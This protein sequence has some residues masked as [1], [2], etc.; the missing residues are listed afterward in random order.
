[1]CR[2]NRKVLFDA[3]TVPPERHCR[4]FLLRLL[5]RWRGTIL[6]DSFQFARAPPAMTNMWPMSSTTQ[7]YAISSSRARRAN[8][9]SP[10]S[11]PKSQNDKFQASLLTFSSFGSATTTTLLAFL[12]CSTAYNPMMITISS[13]PV[14][15]TVAVLCLS[16]L[17]EIGLAFTSRRSFPSFLYSAGSAGSTSKA[18]GSSSNDVTKRPT[19]LYQSASDNPDEP[20][21]FFFRGERK[22]D[23]ENEEWKRAFLGIES[24]NLEDQYQQMMKSD[25]P[26][27]FFFTSDKTKASIQ[28]ERDDL[29]R[30][31]QL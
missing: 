5:C 6:V 16:L 15:V 27:P 3:M 11:S 2:K 20:A 4:R 18:S 10:K 17:C 9:K 19:K 28:Q 23:E 13:I 1:M 21:P 22:S 26:A 24:V 7:M 30:M 14:S 29:E 8:S 31:F 12:L 25:A